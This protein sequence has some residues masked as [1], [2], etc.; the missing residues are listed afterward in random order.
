VQLCGAAGD[1]LAGEAGRGLLR[2][3]GRADRAERNARG[4]AD[5]RDRERLH[6]A[7][8]D[9]HQDG[10]GERNWGTEAGGALEEQ[11]QEPADQDRLHRG[12][13]RET[14]DRLPQHV[15]ASA[16]GLQLVDAERRKDDPEN[17]GGDEPASSKAPAVAAAR[18]PLP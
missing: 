10:R 5:Q 8:P 16:P 11:S 15:E 18:A 4:M 13:G 17:R 12:V 7:E 3:D 9:A 14:F 6:R 1:R 2:Q